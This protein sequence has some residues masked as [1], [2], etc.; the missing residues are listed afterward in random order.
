[1]A[2]KA[3]LSL[4]AAFVALQLAYVYF[5]VQSNAGFFHNVAI[6]LRSGESPLVLINVLFLRGSLQLGVYPYTN[7]VY[8]SLIV[9]LVVLLLVSI[10]IIK[11]RE[12]DLG[13]FLQ[14]NL[15]KLVTAF[16]LLVGS[17]F[18]STFA[19]GFLNPCQ[20]SP[21]ACSYSYGFPLGFYYTSDYSAFSLIFLIFDFLFW[22]FI[23]SAI[24][25][26]RIKY[27]RP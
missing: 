5:F 25:W 2:V 9:D 21:L 26:V 14:F 7:F 10:A 24:Y 13:K 27:F 20:S 1:M 22:Y 8:L 3:V 18:I 6:F 15:F 11:V 19:N 23:A 4:F 16:F 12:N 17:F